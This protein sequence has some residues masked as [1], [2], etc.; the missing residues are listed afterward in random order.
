MTKL[1]ALAGEIK[2]AADMSPLYDAALRYT[3]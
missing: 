3:T 1:K 2:A